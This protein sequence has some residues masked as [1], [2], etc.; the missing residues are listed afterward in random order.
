MTN[1]ASTYHMRRDALI[2]AH[3]YDPESE[4]DAC[5]V[6]LVAALDAKP[7]REIVDMAIAALKA[8]WHRGA[9]D[10]DGKT[11]DGAG[12]RLNVPQ[13]LFS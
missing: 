8:V 10:A 11:G 5:G 2:D 3:A 6:G 12:I 4:H 1:P 9:V 7:R 13:E